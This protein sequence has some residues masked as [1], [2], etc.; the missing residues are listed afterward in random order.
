MKKKMQKIVGIGLFMAGM[1]F[2]SPINAQNQ[3]ERQDR[4]QSRL[5]N[6]RE[7]ERHHLQHHRKGVNRLDG[8]GRSPQA[9]E[10]IHRRTHLK[11]RKSSKIMHRQMH[12]QMRPMNK[13]QSLDRAY[14]SGAMNKKQ[15]KKAKRRLIKQSVTH[16]SIILK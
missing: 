15:Y 5:H 7:Y 2:S 13:K 16:E 6:E 10:N 8:I 1:I 14:K 12:R 9:R 11:H 3:I 4:D